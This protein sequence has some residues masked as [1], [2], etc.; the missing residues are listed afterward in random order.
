[1][2]KLYSLC[3]EKELN[4][5]TITEILLSGITDEIIQEIISN[6]MSID[7]TASGYAD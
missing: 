6:H 2:E 5:V 3:L 4:P 1:M 7:I